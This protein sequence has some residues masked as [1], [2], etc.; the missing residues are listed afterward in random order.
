MA[1]EGV[2]EAIASEDDSAIQCDASERAA[3]HRVC[4]A[5][6]RAAVSRDT[7]ALN[8]A[9]DGAESDSEVGAEC[10]GGRPREGGDGLGLVEDEEYRVELATDLRADRDAAAADRARGRPLKALL[11]F[12]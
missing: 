7:G 12:G 4:V 8:R 6:R 9:S 10:E 2:V 11:I 3:R 1:I 5:R